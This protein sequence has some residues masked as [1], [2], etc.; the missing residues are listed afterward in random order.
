[1]DLIRLNSKLQEIFKRDIPIAAL[2]RYT[3]IDSF[4]HF[5]GD[6]KVETENTPANTRSGARVARIKKGMANKNKR[7]ETRTRRNK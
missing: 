1:M 7:H 5:L 4:S 2:Y 6:G 3:T